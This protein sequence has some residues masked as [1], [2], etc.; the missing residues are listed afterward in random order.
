MYSQKQ[1]ARAG[2]CIRIYLS[3]HTCHKLNDLAL[4]HRSLIRL[5]VNVIVFGPAHL[6]YHTLKHESAAIHYISVSVFFLRVRCSYKHKCGRY[7]N[8]FNMRGV[9]MH[10]Q[11]SSGSMHL[12]FG[13]YVRPNEACLSRLL[14]IV[15]N[16]ICLC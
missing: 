5:L 16:F 12:I 13:P 15:D 2:H 9:I 6:I 14:H 8:A 4:S 3:H 11:P 7:H 10:A 1:C